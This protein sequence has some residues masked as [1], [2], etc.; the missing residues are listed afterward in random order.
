MVES[1]FSP[2][3]T[4]AIAARRVGP[5]NRGGARAFRQGKPKESL[6][7]RD[8]LS[9]ES[10]GRLKSLREPSFRLSRQQFPHSAPSPIEPKPALMHRLLPRGH[11]APLFSARPLL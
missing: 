2:V 9:P 11:R 4:R 6:E 10:L 3:I 1:N 7:P 8:S 5:G